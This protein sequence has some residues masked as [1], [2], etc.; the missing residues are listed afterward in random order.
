MIP[1]DKIAHVVMLP[2]PTL[3]E[4]IEAQ[5][6]KAYG[7]D[8]TEPWE[9]SRASGISSCDR[10]LTLKA[11]LPAGTLIRK[12]LRNFLATRIGTFVHELIQGAGWGDEAVAEET[13]ENEWLRGHSDH[14][15]VADGLLVDYKTAFVDDWFD[16]AVGC[17]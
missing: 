3:V 5:L 8:V 17:R 1:A 4:R 7:F 15:F 9:K 10:A 12:H 6:I 16:V 14:R 13:I 11:G 2:A